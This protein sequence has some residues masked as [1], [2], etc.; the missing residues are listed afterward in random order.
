MDTERRARATRIAA[1]AFGVVVVLWA[2]VKARS[3]VTPFL[4]AFAL[5]YA[6]NPLVNALER[7]FGRILPRRRGRP[8]VSP[9]PAAVG[10]LF[11]LVVAV[12]L[13]ILLFGVPAAF[14]Q[15][16]DAVKK[17]P[18]DFE[19]LRVKLEPKLQ[20]LSERYPNQA[21]AIR[22]QLTTFAKD[23]MGSIVERVTHFIQTTVVG[24]FSV[25]AGA[26]GLLIL[27]IFT[28]F[29]LYDMNHIREDAKDLVPQ[30]LRPY[31]Y[32]RMREVDARVAAFVRGQLTVC[33]IMTVYYAIGL[34]LCGVPVALLIALLMGTF[35]LIP[36]MP[37]V[38]GLPL[39]AILALVDTQS[40]RHVLVVMG[41]V[42]AGQFVEANIISPKIVGHGVG[43]HPVIVLMSVL[44]GG[45]LFGIIGMLVAVPVTA[46][47]SVFWADLRAYYLQ[48]DFYRAN[49]DSAVITPPEP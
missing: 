22:D 48:S 7:G 30:R 20:R 23:N 45:E 1:V 16:S 27:P 31:A 40:F 6:L 35:H 34:S 36:F 39:A 10:V 5:A 49:P 46:A 25:A 26:I 21:E 3:V 32:S 4:L 47:L 11:A 43:L 28:A 15:A 24:A 19:S 18:T 37:T 14:H 8:L 17:L 41:V 38:L 9:R 33:L 12:A 13:L 29:L 2:V 42:A 44:V